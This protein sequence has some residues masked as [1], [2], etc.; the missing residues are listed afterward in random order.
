MVGNKGR[1]KREFRK[2]RIFVSESLQ[3]IDKSISIVIV[4]SVAYATPTMT[5]TSLSRRK[6]VGFS[7]WYPANIFKSYASHPGSVSVDILNGK[8]AN[9]PT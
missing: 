5:P 6:G 4:S 9:F 8:I 7:A 1:K 2:V 3:D